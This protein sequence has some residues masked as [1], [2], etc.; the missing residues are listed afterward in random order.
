MTKERLQDLPLDALH[1]IANRIDV[2]FY[3]NMER[4]TLIEQIIEAFEEE[5]FERENSNNAAMRV[6]ERKFDIIKDEDAISENPDET[7]LAESYNETE[8]TLLLRDPLWAFAYWDLKDTDVEIIKNTPNAQLAL[9]VYQIDVRQKGKSKKY[10]PFEIPVKLSDRK[11]YI[12][13]PTTGQEYSLELI[14]SG[15][16]NQRVLCSSNCIKSPIISINPT[17]DSSV[18]GS[19]YSILAVAGLQESSDFSE[20]GGIPQRIISLLDTQYLHLQ[21]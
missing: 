1:E 20:K 2:T 11:W 10:K 19:F 16:S 3:P 14:L 5:K 4:E 18:D 8:I 13:L 7:D 17:N 21:G 6:E 9:R 12:N 15:G